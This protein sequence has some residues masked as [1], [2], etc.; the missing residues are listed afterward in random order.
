[1]T[2]TPANEFLQNSAWSTIFGILKDSAEPEAQ[3]FAAITLR[4]KV[5]RCGGT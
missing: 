4:G 3:L 2:N 5:D 1:M